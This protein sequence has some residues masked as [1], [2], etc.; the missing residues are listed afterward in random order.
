[1]PLLGMLT[2]PAPVSDPTALLAP[3]FNLAPL[4]TVSAPPVG[5]APLTFACTSELPAIVVAPYSCPP[6]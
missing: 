1:V 4:F 6:R 2:V 5:I 3:N